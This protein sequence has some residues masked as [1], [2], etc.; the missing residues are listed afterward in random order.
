[1]NAIS[2][3][4]IGLAFFI[5][6]AAPGPATISNAV[7]A[8]SHG[9]RVGLIYGAGL[10]LG[11][12]I[13]GVVAASGLG[14][15][16]QGS[17]RMLMML[18]ILGGMYLLWLA[19]RSA[20]AAVKPQAETTHASRS[21][22]WFLR[23]LIL[24]ASNPKAVVAWMAAL[25]VGLDSGAGLPELIAATSMCMTIG[26]VVYV[27]YSVAFSLDGVMRFYTRAK[28]GIDGVMAGLFALFGVGLI[29]SAFSR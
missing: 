9:R 26:L 14:A 28:R 23:G 24:N 12:G 27:F 7:V 11:L 4:S 2:F 25:A 18:K 1:M 21:G 6:A 29:R 20:R 13:W 8:M 16:L 17:V 10:S 19:Y 22:N 3:L 15:I 5:V